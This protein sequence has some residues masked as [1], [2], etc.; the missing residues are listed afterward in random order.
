MFNKLLSI[1]V[2]LAI[3]GSAARAA[4]IGA[5]VQSVSALLNGCPC[6]EHR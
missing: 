5:T 4:Q 2:A 1:G 3:M 6:Q